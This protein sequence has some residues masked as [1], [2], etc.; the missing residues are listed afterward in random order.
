M[1]GVDP[2]Q[3]CTASCFTEQALTPFFSYPLD[4]FPSRSQP[5][6]DGYVSASHLSSKGQRISHSTS[7]C[8]PITNHFLA[9]LLSGRFEDGKSKASLI[10]SVLFSFSTS[11]GVQL[12]CSIALFRDLYQIHVY[13]YPYTHIYIS[14]SRYVSAISK[15]FECKVL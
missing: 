13:L 1:I 10:Q 7:P 5:E 14:A 6:A 12:V 15:T 4:S 9:S 2:T 3:Y 11:P 8:S